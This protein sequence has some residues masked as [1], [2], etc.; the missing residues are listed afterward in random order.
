[1]RPLRVALNLRWCDHDYPRCGWHTLCHG[2]IKAPVLVAPASL[3][4]SEPPAQ[5]RSGPSLCSAP[6]PQCQPALTFAQWGT[7]PEGPPF[8]SRLVSKHI[9]SAN[10]T[11]ICGIYKVDQSVTERYNFVVEPGLPVSPLQGGPAFLM[12]VPRSYAL[13]Y[14]Q[15]EILRG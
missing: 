11:P 5:V 14:V 8:P 9:P 12:P 13:S 15:I 10:K 4:G 6:M 1:M 3:I 2:Q 7:P